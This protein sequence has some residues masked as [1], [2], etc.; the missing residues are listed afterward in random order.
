MG[1]LLDIVK[2]YQAKRPSPIVRHVPCECNGT[3]YPVDQQ[4]CSKCGGA[5]CGLCNGCLVM[6]TALVYERGGLR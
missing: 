6:K 2:R 1:S 3:L 4:H 5:K